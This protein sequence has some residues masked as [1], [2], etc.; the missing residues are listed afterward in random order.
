V[1]PEPTQNRANSKKRQN[2]LKHTKC[3]NTRT[4]IAPAHTHQDGG[5][6]APA[7]T[8]QQKTLLLI[9]VGDF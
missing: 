9:L 7:N 3:A 2:T 1:I 5:F 4:Q 6:L 8:Q